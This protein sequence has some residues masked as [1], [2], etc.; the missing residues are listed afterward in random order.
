VAPRN[1]FAEVGYYTVRDENL[2]PL[3]LME[4]LFEDFENH[5]A[6]VYRF[7][8]DGGSPADLD[9]EARSYFSFLMAGQIIRGKSFRDFDQEAAE[10]LAKQ[11]LRVG[12]VHSRKWWD[13]FLVEMEVDGEELPEIS[14]EQYVEF[15]ER[16]EYTLRH[17]P[18]H[19]TE[20]MLS[21]IKDLAGIFF[22]FDWHIVR[23]D[24]PKLLTAEE[25]ISYW[26]PP[27]PAFMFRGIGPLTSDEVRL[28][29]APDVA[30]VLTHPRLGFRDR[31]G[32]GSEKAAA[33]LNY[34]TWAFRPGQPLVLCPDIEH[35]PFPGP[36][37]YHGIN[38]LLPFTPG[39]TID[40]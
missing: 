6:R 1:A 23:F 26:R 25:P 30:L 13:R 19:M 3:A 29:L 35:H 34:L 22:D 31:V 4:V 11:V 40:R 33:R 2:E 39:P 21:P 32:S 14:R 12:A 28:P 27:S 16:D 24:E 17:S 15:I 7:L 5:A 18:E 36:V 9:A 8:V 10:T 38:H 20:A 37:E